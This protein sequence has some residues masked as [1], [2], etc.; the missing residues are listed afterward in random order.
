MDGGSDW[1][2]LRIVFRVCQK[3]FGYRSWRKVWEEVKVDDCAFTLLLL[4]CFFIIVVL[5]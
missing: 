5:E 1:D 2:G 3:P 4:L